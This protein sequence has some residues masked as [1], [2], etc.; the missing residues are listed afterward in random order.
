[1]K[2]EQKEEYS[3]KEIQESLKEPFD[4]GSKEYFEIIKKIHANREKYKQEQTVKQILKYKCIKGV[5]DK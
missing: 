4:Y 5:Y 2:N 1:M 3:E